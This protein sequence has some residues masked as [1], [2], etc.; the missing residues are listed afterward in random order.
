MCPYR[1]YLSVIEAITI[2]LIAT[3]H[4]I[5]YLCTETVLLSY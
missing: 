5:Y 3:S 1:V 2:Q 4:K